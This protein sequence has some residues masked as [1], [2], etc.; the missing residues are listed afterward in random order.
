VKRLVSR[1][2]YSL[3]PL[4]FIDVM[5]DFAEKRYDA[6]R[7]FMRFRLN[8]VKESGRPNAGLVTILLHFIMQTEKGLATHTDVIR[9]SSMME[10]IHNGQNGSW[11]NQWQ[12][13]IQACETLKTQWG[14]ETFE[15]VW[16]RGNGQT[17][18]EQLLKFS[19]EV[20]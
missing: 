20:L 14:A 19:E 16:A 6:I 12:R 17:L 11:I 7:D 5:I 8:I 9:M 3:I 4:E 2:Y 10:Y 18:D 13:Y 1:V 15:A